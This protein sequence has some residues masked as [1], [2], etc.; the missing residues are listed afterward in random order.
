MSDNRPDRFCQQWCTF[1][2]KPMFSLSGDFSPFPFYPTQ[3]DVL[4]LYVIPLFIRFYTFILLRGSQCHY[5]FGFFC[6]II[7]CQDMT[8]NCR[9]RRQGGAGALLS[10][11]CLH[12]HG[13]T[14]V[15]QLCQ[16]TLGTL[17]PLKSSQNIYCIP[18]E[19]KFGGNKIYI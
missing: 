3:F 1:A 15:L 10:R 16:A 17:Y 7:S 9:R 13:D 14:I 8:L 4:V 19:Q 5:S 6:R 12:L 18:D 11:P 2:R